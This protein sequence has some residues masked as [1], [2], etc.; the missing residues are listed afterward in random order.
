MT[1]IL[2]CA[3]LSLKAMV[4]RRGGCNVKFV[5][6]EFLSVTDISIVSLRWMTQEL[7]DDRSTLFQ[8]IAWCW[9]HQAIWRH[10]ASVVHNKLT[11]KTHAPR[12]HPEEQCEPVGWESLVSI[13][14]IWRQQHMAKS[15]TERTNYLHRYVYSIIQV[16]SALLGL[17]AIS[18]M[19]PYYWCVLTLIPA[20]IRTYMP[21]KVWD[22]ITYPWP[23][24]FGNG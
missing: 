21:S 22:E 5:V 8:V 12:C 24:E 15:K 1:N 11:C 3:C 7:V 17:V 18:F 2:T 16:I 20:W 14:G 6:S 10:M 9:R 4:N 19:G 13:Y 23:L